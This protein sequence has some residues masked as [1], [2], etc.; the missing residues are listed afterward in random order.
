MASLPSYTNI[1]S[2]LDSNTKIIADASVDSVSSY[3]CSPNFHVVNPNV[4]F[5]HADGYYGSN[6]IN[7]YCGN[8]GYL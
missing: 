2:Q 6:L 3:F 8:V 1:Q 7:Y 5:S 4:T